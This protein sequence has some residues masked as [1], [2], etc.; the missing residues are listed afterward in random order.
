MRGTRI[1]QWLEMREANYTIL[2]SESKN[3]NP[4]P[5]PQ[6]LQK[7][8]RGE[9]GE[10]ASSLSFSTDDSPAAITSEDGLL[11]VPDSVRLHRQN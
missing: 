8:L 3:S 2:A 11:R 10:A 9:I 4:S 6:L 5:I 1:L 7:P